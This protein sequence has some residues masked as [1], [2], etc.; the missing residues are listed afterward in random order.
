MVPRLSLRLPNLPVSVTVRACGETLRSTRR[1][2][3]VASQLPQRSFGRTT[4]F[5]KS[6]VS[7]RRR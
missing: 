5:W 6:T 2:C 3:T 7:I 4:T 1:I